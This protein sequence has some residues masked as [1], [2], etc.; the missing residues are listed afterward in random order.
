M[1]SDATEKVSTEPAAEPEKLNYC[2][3]RPWP[4]SPSNPDGTSLCIYMY[5]S[6]VKHGTMEDAE[7][8]RDYVN[9]KTKEENFIYKL[10]Q[11]TP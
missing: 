10:V 4:K 5:G 7:G 3:G 1:S 8:F 2:V 9:E 11:V 6:Q